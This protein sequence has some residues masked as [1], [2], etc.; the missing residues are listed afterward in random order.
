MLDKLSAAS[1]SGYSCRE[2]SELEAVVAVD[3]VVVGPLF[4][5]KFLSC[6]DVAA[7]RN[8]QF[9]AVVVLDAA[10]APF[11]PLVIAHAN[12][13]A[14]ARMAEQILGDIF[15]AQQIFGL[16]IEVQQHRQFH[17]LH[18]P[19]LDQAAQLIVAD[20]RPSD[21][22]NAIVF[23]VASL[24]DEGRVGDSI[25]L[26]LGDFEVQQIAGVVDEELGVLFVGLSDLPFV[27][28]LVLADGVQGS[29]RRTLH[30]I[31]IQH[32]A[33]ANRCQVFSFLGWNR[34]VHC[35]LPFF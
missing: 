24:G 6:W 12:V 33:K 32:K 19:F 21:L 26:L 23:L 34:K 17:L 29:L 1:C 22:G 30:S 10:V 20:N 7:G 31:I 18:P 9:E 13:L 3:E 5:D 25:D 16:S 35:Y 14:V 15:G 8:E 27:S 4:E 2:V 11:G 28:A